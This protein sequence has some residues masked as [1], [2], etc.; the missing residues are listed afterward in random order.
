[1]QVFGILMINPWHHQGMQGL[2]LDSLRLKM[3][4]LHFHTNITTRTDPAWRKLQALRS[5][6]CT[7]QGIGDGKHIQWQYG[8]AA[9]A[10]GIDQDAYVNKIIRYN[11]MAN[12]NIFMSI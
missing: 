12:Y 2:V 8:T 1:M 5:R 7:Q 6:P 10:G 4:T 9:Q 3:Q 11:H